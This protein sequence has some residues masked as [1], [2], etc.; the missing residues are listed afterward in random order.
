MV[1]FLPFTGLIPKLSDIED[2]GDRVSPPY[3]VIGDEERQRLQSAKGNIT[4]I[5]LGAKE[6]DYDEAARELAKWIDEGRLVSTHEDCYYLYRQTFV[7]HGKELART[8]IMGR[9]RL[10]S[11]DKGNIMPHEETFPKVKEDRL[12]LLRATSAHLESIFGIFDRMDKKVLESLERAEKLF[13]YEDPAGGRH[14]FSI[15]RDKGTIEQLR[16]FL[17][18]KKLLIADGHHR[19]ETALKYSMENPGDRDKGYVLA[20][21]VASDDPGLVVEPTHRLLKSINIPPEQFMNATVKDFGIWEMRSLEELG[22]A[23][24]RSKRV[25]IGIMFR[26]GKIFALDHVRPPNDDPMW[27]IDTYVCEE[28]VIK[29]VQSILPADN[30]MKVEYDHA[31]ESV[32]EKMRGGGY[33]MAIILSPPQLETIWTLAKS[34]RKMPKKSTYFYPKV[35]SGF[36]IYQM[37]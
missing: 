34:G 36:V 21:L 18:A 16:S 10:E 17:A 8:G 35:W 13:D 6:G 5:T 29:P 11:Y 20:T 4:R 7:A 26:D 15:I 19:Y 1:E 25:M 2:I 32:R 31:L 28:L 27:S 22:R 23:M 9:L 3:D 33:D 30:Q 37:R 14:S 12:N 24:S